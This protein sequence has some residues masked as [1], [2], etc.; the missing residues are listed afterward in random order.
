MIR[1]PSLPQNASFFHSNTR[2]LAISGLFALTL[3]ILVP[4]LPSIGREYVLVLFNVTDRHSKIF[5]HSWL[6]PL[7]TCR[8][9]LHVP[10]AGAHYQLKHSLS[11][12]KRHTSRGRDIQLQDHHSRYTENTG[13]VLWVFL[14]DCDALGWESFASVGRLCA[15]VF[16]GSPQGSARDRQVPSE[17]IHLNPYEQEVLH[18][19][20]EPY[21]QPTV[22]TN[23]QFKQIF[24]LL[25]LFLWN[26][27]ENRAPQCFCNDYK[28]EIIILWPIIR[29]CDVTYDIVYW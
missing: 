15:V 19:S 23:V 7:D 21:A 1:S 20:C 17:Q 3:K 25:A 27:L 10:V 6:I 28:C 12:H 13:C 5:R 14:D 2:E 9:L 18:P 11:H 29:C 24:Y 22:S 4:W 26:N 16:R 8:T